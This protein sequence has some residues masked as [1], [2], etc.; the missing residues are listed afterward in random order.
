MSIEGPAN[1]HDRSPNLRIGLNLNNSSYCGL[2]G[3][4]KYVFISHSMGIL[5]ASPDIL[6]RYTRGETITGEIYPISIGGT[7]PPYADVLRSMKFFSISE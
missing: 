7:D 6:Y 5:L 2:T 1:M 4:G 3:D